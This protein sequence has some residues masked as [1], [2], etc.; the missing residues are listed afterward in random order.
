L[1]SYAHVLRVALPRD[2]QRT[3]DQ[4]IV[5]LDQQE[6]SALRPALSALRQEQ[7]QLQAD[8]TL[9]QVQNAVLFVLVEREMTR[10]EG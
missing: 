3:L 1:T 5:E 8:L 7:R 6:W 10:N 4:L 2:E 9:L